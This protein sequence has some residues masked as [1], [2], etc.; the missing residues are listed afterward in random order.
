MFRPR[1]VLFLIVFWSR[2]ESCIVTTGPVLGTMTGE[3]RTSD[4]PA[5][6][7]LEL[8]VIGTGEKEDAWMDSLNVRTRRPRFLSKVYVDRVG[9]IRSAVTALACM[10][11]PVACKGSE[12]M[13]LMAP[14]A[15]ET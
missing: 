15:R 13:S 12:A 6:V 4:C 11:E 7:E 10:G 5:P 8:S 3:E 2:R 1:S 9:G 14:F